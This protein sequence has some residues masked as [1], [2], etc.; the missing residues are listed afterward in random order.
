MHSAKK[1][2]VLNILTLLKSNPNEKSKNRKTRFVEYKLIIK[3]LLHKFQNSIDENLVEHLFEGLQK[4]K[5]NDIVL[6]K[7]WWL[8][9]LDLITSNGSNRA[10]KMKD[11]LLLTNH[12]SAINLTCS[13][14]LEMY[15]FCLEYGLYEAGLIFRDSACK[16][17]VSE[18]RLNPGDTISQLRKLV[19]HFEQKD[20]LLKESLNAV[21]EKIPNNK[22][23]RAMKYFLAKLF[24]WQSQSNFENHKLGHFVSSQYSSMI[25]GSSVAVVSRAAF[26]TERG[27]EIDSFDYVVRTNYR[28]GDLSPRAQF[29]GERIDISYYNGETATNIL[30]EDNGIIPSGLKAAVFKLPVEHLF[31]GTAI[32]RHL[33]L[34]L[35]LLTFESSAYSLPNIIADLMLHNPQKIKVFSA[36]ALLTNKRPTF[37]GQ[38]AGKYTSNKS[39]NYPRRHDVI[40]NYIFLLHFYKRGFIEGDTHFNY[41]MELGVERYVRKLQKQ[42]IEPAI[43]SSLN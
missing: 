30:N 42:W 31:N 34:F 39:P 4:I 3:N 35:D 16:A 15:Y 9:F 1:R 20:D 22:E 33:N 11:F 37:Y 32:K 28:G 27:S 21:E 13:E 25:K 36:D 29:D 7:G 17:A 19:I 23:I 40:T 6:D 18:A 43:D 24:N 8:S 38:A 10:T 14:G 12:L 41:A 2:I 5:N 26:D